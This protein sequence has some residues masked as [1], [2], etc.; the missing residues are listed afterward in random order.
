MNKLLLVSILAVVSTAAQAENTASS[1]IYAGAELGYSKVSDSSQASANTLVSNFG[2]SASVTQDSGVAIGRLF[3]GYAFNENFGAELGYIK[4]G[5]VTQ[6]ATG[7]EGGGVTYTAKQTISYSGIDYAVLVRP[8][9]STGWN[10]LFA[11][12]GGHYL[13]GSNDITMSAAGQSA[14]EG[15]KIKGSG[16]LFGFGYEAPIAN[17]INFRATYTHYNNISGANDNANVAS[18]GILAKF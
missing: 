13:E 8:S 6:Q 18:I 9:I 1:G 5:D 16:F 3:G 11:K 7:V 14:S 4:S 2:G 12:I 15:T 17:N 10:G